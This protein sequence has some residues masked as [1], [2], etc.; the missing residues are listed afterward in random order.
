ME[1]EIIRLAFQTFQEVKLIVVLQL[2][3][4][5]GKF[6]ASCWTKKTMASGGGFNTLS[7][8]STELN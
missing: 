2:S 8:H 7:N 3:S 5:Y 1:S 4:T 6:V